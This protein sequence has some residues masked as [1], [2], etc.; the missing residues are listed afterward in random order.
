MLA[1]IDKTN[2]DLFIGKLDFVVSPSVDLD[3][4]FDPKDVV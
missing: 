2:E 4:G 3:D 1:K